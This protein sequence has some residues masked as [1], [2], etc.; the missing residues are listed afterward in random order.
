MHPSI[1]DSGI[2][3]KVYKVAYRRLEREGL[4]VEKGVWRSKRRERRKGR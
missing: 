4:V 2:F 3:R 1:N